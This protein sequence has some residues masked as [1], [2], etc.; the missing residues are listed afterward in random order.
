MVSPLDF[1]KLGTVYIEKDVAQNRYDI[2]KGCE[3]FLPTTQ[4][5]KCLC[6]MKAKVKLAEAECPLGKWLKQ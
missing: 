4:C 6:F 5:S 2:C 1:L 3:H